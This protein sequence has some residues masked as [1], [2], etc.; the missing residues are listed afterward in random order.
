MDPVTQTYQW[1]AEQESKKAGE[2]TEPSNRFWPSEMGGCSR[3]IYY[4]M[5]GGLVQPPGRA[6]MYPISEDGDIA[7]DSV[8]WNLRKA[9]VELDWLDFNEETNTI[10]ETKSFQY[11]MTLH[12]KEYVISGRCDGRIKVD[13]EWMPLEIKSLNG[14]GYKYVLKAYNEGRILDYISEKYL[15]YLIQTLL[16]AESLGYDKTYLIIK[17]RSSCQFGLHDEANDVR[18][19][20]II[21]ND[22][23][24]LERLQKKM[25]SI[26]KSLHS[27]VEPPRAYTEKSKE[28]GW[29]PYKEMCWRTQG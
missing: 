20:M 1:F 24:L 4:R 10:V 27:D 28:C 13:G 11:P 5:R 23:V 16:C 21:H 17:D 3:A 6:H 19:G 22:P 7:H 8:R 18:E 29:C 25:S 12:G 15:K 9:G 14:F 2:I 26:A